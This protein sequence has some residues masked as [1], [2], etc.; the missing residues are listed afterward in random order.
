MRKLL[1]RIYTSANGFT[2]IELLLVIAIIS[3]LILAVMFALNPFEQIK[4][5]NDGRRKSD[6][7]EIQKALELYYQDNGSYP[8]QNQQTLAPEWGDDQAQYIAKMPQDPK[9][10][11]MRYVYVFLDNDKYA[12]YASLERGTHDPQACGGS[13]NNTCNFTG[14]GGNTNVCGGSGCNYGV[15]SPNITP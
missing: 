15:S 14:L 3:I 7:S 11:G 12:L 6:L 5:A 1:A 8:P 13:Q 10:P 2:L 4:K 9:S